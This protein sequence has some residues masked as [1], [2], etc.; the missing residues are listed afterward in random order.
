MQTSSPIP[1]KAN[2][3]YYMEIVMFNSGGSGLMSLAVRMPSNT[4]IGPIP[5]YL[6]GFLSMFKKNK[7]V[8]K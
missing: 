5:S 8:C 7:Y 1:L 6:L 2:Y 3:S 4:F